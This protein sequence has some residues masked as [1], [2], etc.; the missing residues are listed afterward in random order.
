M[1][2]EVPLVEVPPLRMDAVLVHVRSRLEPQPTQIRVHVLDTDAVPHAAG[3]RARGDDGVV[4]VRGG[5]SEA[6][7]VRE[8]VHDGKSGIGRPE[9][10][11][12]PQN[13]KRC[14]VRQMGNTA[15]RLAA[16]VGLALGLELPFSSSSL[17]AEGID[18]VRFVLGSKAE[19][20][21]RWV[22]DGGGGD[23]AEGR[24]EE[25]REW[26]AVAVRLTEG[27][28][29]PIDARG[30]AEGGPV[31]ERI[32]VEDLSAVFEPAPPPRQKSP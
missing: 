23:T 21:R 10:K 24:A 9:S 18:P 29:V 12:A 26:E 11:T 22:T 5:G 4:D 2:R 7:E 30:F 20:A 1:L 15:V 8:G 19:E 28:G 25:V 14:W 17:R 13:G 31:L 27:V 3:Q 16:T 6:V 32:V